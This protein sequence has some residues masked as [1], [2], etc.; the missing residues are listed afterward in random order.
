MREREGG[1][2]GRGKRK[3]EKGVADLH[4]FLCSD[5]PNDRLHRTGVSAALVGKPGQEPL[6]QLLNLPENK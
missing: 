6:I 5:G 2:E 4:D 1:K 3:G